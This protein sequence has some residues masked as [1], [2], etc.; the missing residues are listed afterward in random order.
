MLI[1]V[2]LTLQWPI[3]ASMLYI[4]LGSLPLFQSFDKIF[5]A[6]LFAIL[7]NHDHEYY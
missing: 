4:N 5:T 1:I 2:Q 3:T 6:Y 7:C